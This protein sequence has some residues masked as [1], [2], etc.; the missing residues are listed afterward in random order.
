MREDGVFIAPRDATP[1]HARGMIGTHVHQE[2]FFFSDEVHIKSI[3]ICEIRKIYHLSLPH[4][5]S[6][7]MWCEYVDSASKVFT[8]TFL[9]GEVRGGFIVEIFGRIMAIGCF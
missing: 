1:S 6:P 7:R 3:V 5:S 8:P 9:F 4:Q 2:K